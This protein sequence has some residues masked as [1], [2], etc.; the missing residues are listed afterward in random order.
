LIKSF[1]EFQSLDKELRTTYGF[2][3]LPSLPM[4]VKFINRLFSRQHRLCAALN[5]W[6]EDVLIREGVNNN[7]AVHKFLKVTSYGSNLNDVFTKRALGNLGF[8]S[9]STISV[10][11]T[12]TT[13]SDHLSVIVESDEN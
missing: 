10:V 11:D 13:L 3:D 6:M 12:S 1:K 7:L 5:A 2:K 8:D 9:G 4:N